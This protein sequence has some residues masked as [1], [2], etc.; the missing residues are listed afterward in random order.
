MDTILNFF[1]LFVTLCYHF[2][3]AESEALDIFGTEESE[4]CVQDLDVVFVLD[5]S[6]S[7][8]SENFDKVKLWV[9]HLAVGLHIDH[10]HVQIGLVQYSSYYEKRPMNR[11]KFLKTEI[12]LGEF[13][14]EADFS[15]AVD[16]IE[17]Q[18]GK[19]TY[20]A[21]AIE[22]TIIYDLKGVSSRYPIAKRTIVLLTDGK[23]KDGNDIPRVLDLTHKTETR[24]IPVG[25]GDYNHDELVL[26]S[27]NHTERVFE[28]ENFDD[29]E[30][31]VSDVYSSLK[32]ACSCNLKGSI[33]LICDP[34]TSQCKCRPNIEGINCDSCKDNYYGFNNPN[35]CERCQCYGNGTIDSTPCNKETG[36]CACKFEFSGVNCDQCNEGYYNFPT[37][38][39]CECNGFAWDCDD[40][41]V[42]LDCEEGLV[43]DHCET[44]GPG[45]WWDPAVETCYPC[46]CNGH[47]DIDDPRS[48]DPNTGKCLKC[49]NNREGDECEKCKENYWM[50]DNECVECECNKKGTA[51]EMCTSGDC[52]CDQENGRCTCSPNVVGDK[53]DKCAPNHTNMQ[54][55][56]GCVECDCDEIGTLEQTFCNTNTS[57]CQ[58]KENHRGRNCR[59]CDTGFQRKDLQSP[60][61]E[62]VRP[63]QPK[64]T[65]KPPAPLEKTTTKKRPPVNPKWSP[66]VGCGGGST[67]SR[68][69]WPSYCRG[70]TCRTRYPQ[71][72]NYQWSARRCSPYNYGCRANVDYYNDYYQPSYYQPTSY[73]LYNKP[74]RRYIA[75]SMHRSRRHHTHK[76]YS[77]G[78]SYG[79]YLNRY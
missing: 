42:C 21:K 60:C 6:S 52:T 5:G 44:C 12:T 36:E 55:G 1:L 74:S 38:T 39:S 31:I 29:L 25:V 66:C 54:I 40:N 57:E 46:F 41:G 18:N 45:T 3:V 59:E 11:Q 19:Q 70:W 35:G 22:K 34:C 68:S 78:S 10:G 4:G 49:Q 16:A 76:R 75:P 71:Y 32:T 14:S 20:T 62:I 77:S 51:S 9:K 23:A 72:D 2:S 67:W 47:I 30:S 15:K 73:G 33:D 50:K 7:V 8:T 56:I 65:T 58:C 53:C 37:C 43:G 61:V 63:T 28:V 26:I 64:T 27:D 17:Y 13:T 79:L 69:T 24:I 48:C